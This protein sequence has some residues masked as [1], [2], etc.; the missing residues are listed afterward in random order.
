MLTFAKRSLTVAHCVEQR[1]VCILP[2]RLLKK[3]ETRDVIIII[4]ILLLKV[5]NMQ[6]NNRHCVNTGDYK[7][8]VPILQYGDSR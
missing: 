8:T 5:D 7:K 1:G 3:Q 2:A 6:P 4:V